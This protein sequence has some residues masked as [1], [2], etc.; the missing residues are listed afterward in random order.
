MQ[1]VYDWLTLIIFS[2]LIVLFLERSTKGSREDPLWMYM[3]AGVLCAVA[4]YLGN[5]GQQ[6]GAVLVLVANIA[7]IAWYL[8]PLNLIRGR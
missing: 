1:T 8:N 6:I 5:N 7:F 3:L 2:G 4:N